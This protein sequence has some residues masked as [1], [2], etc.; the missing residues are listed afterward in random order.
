MNYQ[1]RLNTWERGRFAPP[2]EPELSPFPPSFTQ[3]VTMRDGVALYTEVFLPNGTMDG[4]QVETSLPVV[5]T[6]S[7]Y[8]YSRPSRNDKRPLSRYLEAGFAVVFQLTRGQGK[9][10]GTFHFFTDD[11]NDGYDA[12][13]WIAEQ[14]WCNGSVGMEG[15][16][17][18]GGTQLLAARAKPPA[19]KCIMPTAFIGDYTKTFPYCN[20]VPNLNMLCNG[21]R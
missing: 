5:L 18:V 21:T 1:D 2:P 8:P 6:R 20:G 10:E 13:E 14:P 16:S 3:R 17:Y 19:L 7:P 9:S 15:S 11:I 4:E 12:I